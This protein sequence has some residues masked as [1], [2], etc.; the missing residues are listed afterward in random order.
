MDSENREKAHYKEKAMAKIELIVTTAFGLEAVVA[1]EIRQL[2]YED[3]TVD[4]GKVTFT[5]DET[6]ICR[7]N[8][9]LR[10]AGRVLIKV[11]EFKATTF[12][13]LF[14]QTKALPWAD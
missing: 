2:G 5:S 14:E 13:E 8:L 4:N 12:D 10:T 11:G 3:I 7:T 9:W 1:R 6:A